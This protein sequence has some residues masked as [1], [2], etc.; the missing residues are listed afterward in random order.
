M[1]FDS[2]FLTQYAKLIEKKFGIRVEFR[3]LVSEYTTLRDLSRLIDGKLS[4]PKELV[5]L[6]HRKNGQIHNFVKFQPKGTRN[7]LIIL[8]G[9]NADNF[10]P[11]YLGDDQPY[12]GFIHPGSDGEEIRFRSVKEMAGAYLEQLLAHKPEGPYFLGGFSFGGLVA[13]EMAV[14]LTRMGHKVPFVILFDTFAHQEPFK[15]YSGFF[16]IIKSNILVPPAMKVIKLVK[17]SICESYL[18][19]KKRTPI[20]LRSFYIINKYSR[21]MKTYT[22]E[23]YSGKVVLF[24]A[25]E[26]NSKMQSLGWEKYVPDL[27]VI[28][29]KADHLSILKDQASIEKI[30][31]EVKKLVETYN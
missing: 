27:T 29:I 4:P 13:F 2:L 21:L 15:W 20:Y 10:I 11:E 5:E 25:L 24:R 16:R 23:K 19:L 22:P 26:N 1:G 7:P 30:R 9:Q 12:F 8:H 31:V 17:S 18:F 3:Q 28:P 14:E 6:T